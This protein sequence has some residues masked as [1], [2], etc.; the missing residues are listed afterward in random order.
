MFKIPLW[1]VFVEI[2]TAVETVD[3]ILSSEDPR[4]FIGKMDPEEKATRK[5][6]IEEFRKRYVK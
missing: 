2:V 1:D 5:K 4:W 6:A 3:E